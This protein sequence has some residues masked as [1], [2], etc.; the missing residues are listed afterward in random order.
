MLAL[1]YE[2]QVY[3]LKD[4]RVGGEELPLRVKVDCSCIA[5]G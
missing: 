2:A 1:V 5:N 3:Y 4:A